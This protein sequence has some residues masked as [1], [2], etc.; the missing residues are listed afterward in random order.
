MCNVKTTKILLYDE[1]IQTNSLLKIFNLNCCL[2]QKKYLLKLQNIK[3]WTRMKKLL[4][5]MIIKYT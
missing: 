1:H 5:S 4:K 3:I 2:F